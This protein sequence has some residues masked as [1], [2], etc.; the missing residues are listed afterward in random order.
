MTHPSLKLKNTHQTYKIIIFCV[1]RTFLPSVGGK[2]A[3]EME[4][5]MSEFLTGI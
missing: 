2:T 5:E 3:L 4:F 1:N